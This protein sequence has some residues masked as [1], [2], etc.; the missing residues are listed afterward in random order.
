M[1]AVAAVAVA[2]RQVRLLFPAR[3]GEG[4]AERAPISTEVER[5]LR[6]P[7]QAWAARSLRAVRR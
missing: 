4:L 6:Y 2:R 5:V 3:C 7:D 1:S